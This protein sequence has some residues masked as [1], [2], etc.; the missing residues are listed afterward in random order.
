MDIRPIRTDQDH[1]AALLARFARPPRPRSRLGFSERVVVPHTD[2]VNT[3][4]GS[5]LSRWLSGRSRVLD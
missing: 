5:G 4:S 1:R 2:G 3:K